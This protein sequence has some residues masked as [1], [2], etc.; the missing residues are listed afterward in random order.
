MT[1]QRK[2]PNELERDI[3]DVFLAADGD[4]SAKDVR[5]H[6]IHRGMNPSEAIIR[7][8]LSKLESERVITRAG[9]YRGP[10][11]VYWRLA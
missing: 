11:R 3:V 1:S 10:Q 6:L 2:Y 8:A 9:E 5:E 4:L 7:R